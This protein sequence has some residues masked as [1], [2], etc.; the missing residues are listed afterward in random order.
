MALR[1]RTIQAHLDGHG[2]DPD[3]SDRATGL[4]PRPTNTFT[5]DRKGWW[6]VWAEFIHETKLMRKA[7]MMLRLK[8]QCATSEG[9]QIRDRRCCSVDCLEH[10]ITQGDCLEHHIYHQMIVIH[11]V[12]TI[13]F[14]LDW[15]PLITRCSSFTSS[16]GP[17]L[18]ILIVSQLGLD[19]SL[20]VIFTIIHLLN[21]S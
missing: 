6:Q 3:L 11:S 14:V 12:I 15:G 1:R 7:V 19:N 4:W 10:Q 9:Q 18:T 8:V 17:I 13:S 21:P 20:D 2:L 16:F 5:R